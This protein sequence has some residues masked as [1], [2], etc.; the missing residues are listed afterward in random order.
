MSTICLLLAL[1]SKY[2]Y[3]IHRYKMCV[4]V[5][6]KGVSGVYV[7]VCVCEKHLLRSRRKHLSAVVS[8]LQPLLT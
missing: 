1:A 6:V 3:K 4:C 2:I 8:W 7:C 5:G